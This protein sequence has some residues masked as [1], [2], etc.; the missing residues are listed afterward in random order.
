MAIQ[1][2]KVHIPNTTLND[3]QE[4]LVQ[5]RW[6]DEIPDS[7]WNHGT[8]L[9]YLKELVEYW[10]DKFDWREQEAKLNRFEQSKAQVD[11]VNIHFIHMRGKSSHPIPIILTHGWPDSF[12]RFYKVIPMLTDPEKFGGKA[13][14][15]FDVIVPSI[16]GFGFSDR[17]AM[18]DGAV[19]GLW[20]KLMTQVLGYDNFTAAGGDLGTGVTKSLALK[21]ADVV[22]AIHLTDV[23][24]PTGQEDYS[25]MSEAERQFAGFTQR[26]LFT[27]GAYIMIQAT[28]P[29][30]LG[31]GLNDSPI[32]L[33][34]WIVE[35]FYAWSDCKG[36]I[37][38]SFTKDE[39]LTNVMIYWITETI[40]SSIRMYSENARSAYA[41]APTTK[42]VR[43]QVPAAV[44]SFPADVP[45]PREWAERNVD[46][47]R[48]TKMPRGGHF[49]AMEEPELFVADLREFFRGF[50]E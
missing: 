10:K 3:L 38:K 36:N 1:P 27:E 15:S 26:W 49:A 16:P 14:D 8:N 12:Y 46:L 42:L 35:K 29:Q 40:N 21:H 32:G 43:S 39:L 37:E 18:T 31:Y 20:A 5:T 45:F 34:S 11:G 7:G 44:A 9:G 19:A 22:A 30:T 23:G 33:A 25:S 2:F 50:R 41:Q 47:K 17:K 6:P 28:K 48:W 13:E 4:R 24:Y